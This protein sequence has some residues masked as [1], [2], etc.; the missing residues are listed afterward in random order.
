MDENSLVFD[1]YLIANILRALANAYPN[2]K[3]TKETIDIYVARLNYY[4]PELL[5][6]ATVACIDECKFF[7]TVAEIKTKAVFF[8]AQDR[9]TTESRARDYLEERRM[10]KFVDDGLSR[11]L[12]EARK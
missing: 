7:P 5:K 4:P 8:Y 2:F 12:L 3:F 6:E 10:G 11:N 9:G 1:D